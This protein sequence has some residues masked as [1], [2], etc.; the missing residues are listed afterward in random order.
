[1]NVAVDDLQISHPPKI[2]ERRPRK[3]TVLA[4]HA[5]EWHAMIDFRGLSQSGAGF[6][7]ASILQTLE[8]L[9]LVAGSRPEIPGGDTGCMPARVQVWP[10]APKIDVPSKRIGRLPAHAAETRTAGQG[11]LAKW[12]R[13]Y[14]KACRQIVFPSCRPE[15]PGP[16]LR[17]AGSSGERAGQAVGTDRMRP[18]VR[19]DSPARRGR[20]E[21]L[22]QR[23][24]EHRCREN[25]RQRFSQPRERLP[26]SCVAPFRH[27]HTLQV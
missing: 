14:A 25:R 12:C 16:S 27:G 2:E 4:P 17:S 11:A 3:A 18:P 19:I 13:R 9:N 8:Q 1:M 5:E 6:G 21:G 22:L 20:N 10:A 15:A 24:R 7:T 23:M 26:V